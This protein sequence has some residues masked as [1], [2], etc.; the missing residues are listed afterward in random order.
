MVYELEGCRMD[1]ACIVVTTT[2]KS[3]IILT[4]L[5]MLKMNFQVIDHIFIIQLAPK[6]HNLL[7][8]S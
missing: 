1:W 4:E 7:L 8:E 2:Q 6:V 5:K 3:S